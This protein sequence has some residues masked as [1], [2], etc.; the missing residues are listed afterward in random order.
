MAKVMGKNILLNDEEAALLVEGKNYELVPNQ[1]G[2]FLL[3]DKEL[4]KEP[5][6]QEKQKKRVI[7]EEM[8]EEKQQV[9]GLIKKLNLSDLVEGKFEKILNEKQRKALLSLVATGKVIVFK[10]NESYKKGVYRIG[11]ESCFEKSKEKKESQYFDAKEKLFDEYTLEQ[12]GFLIIKDREKATQASLLYEKE[13]RGGELKGIK[14]FDG[15]YYLIQTNLLQNYTKKIISA[16]KEKNNQQLEELAKK[17]NASKQ[18]T[19]I[20]CEFLKEEGEILE[21]KKEYYTYIT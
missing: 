3:I 15:N 11:E 20:T 12:D 4:T 1:E 19:K 18:L 21:K 8:D 10:L 9:I 13:I 2:M 16:L 6:R 14:S 17:I 7:S 5:T